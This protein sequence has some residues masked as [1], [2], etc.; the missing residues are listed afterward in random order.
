MCSTR[1][2]LS[3]TK[4]AGVRACGERERRT[5]AAG[6]KVLLAVWKNMCPEI[7]GALLLYGGPSAALRNAQGSCTQT[8]TSHCTVHH[9][10]GFK[11]I[12]LFILKSLDG[13]CVHSVGWCARCLHGSSGVVGN[14]NV[15]V[16]QSFVTP[17]E[18][19]TRDIPDANRIARV[20]THL[21]PRAHTAPVSG[22]GR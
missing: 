18:G 9:I 8:H 21:P 11:L 5:S 17:S 12:A 22:R 19:G 14:K 1:S 7:N 16:S 13:R 6:R 15:W 2:L 4:R 10:Y 20:N 3:G